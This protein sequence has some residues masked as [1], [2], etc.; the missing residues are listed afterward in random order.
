MTTNDILVPVDF[1]DC[2]DELVQEAA[3]I[4]RQRKG[5]LL[6]LHVYEVPSGMSLD[7]TISPDGGEVQT[8]DDYL[9]SKA[10]NRLAPYLESAKSMEIPARSIVRSGKVAST[11][12]G[13]ASE[14]GTD[15][16]VMG[17]RGRGGVARVLLGSVANAVQRDAPCPVTT[18]QTEYKASC[19]ARSCGW[20]ASHVTPELQQLRAEADG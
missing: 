16:I 11:I 5:R 14:L 2:S 6:L 19:E 15:L 10:K 1:S 7:A 3:Q 12:V 20:C 4:A 17:T 8:V 18:V 9:R 13:V